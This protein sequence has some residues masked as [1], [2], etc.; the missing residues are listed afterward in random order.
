MKLYHHLNQ[1]TKKELFT[2]KTTD[3]QINNIL[4]NYIEDEFFRADDD[5]YINMWNLYNLFTESSKSNYIDN[6]LV[7]NANAY[8]FVNHLAGAI[9]YHTE[10]YFLQI[11]NEHHN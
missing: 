5:G 4:K 7:R 8:G 3:S 9:K 10:N 1:N 11:P 6:F 2:L